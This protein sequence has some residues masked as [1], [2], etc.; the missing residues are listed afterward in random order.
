MQQRQGRPHDVLAFQTGIHMAGLGWPEADP[1]A[2][3]RI[4]L[5]SVDFSG[6]HIFPLKT[7]S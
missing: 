7:S 4:E 2:I 5:R 1:K 3:A 6:L